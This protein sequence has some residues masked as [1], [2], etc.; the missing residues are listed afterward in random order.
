MRCEDCGT[1][2]RGGLCPNCHEE[3]YI[4]NY[5][6]DTYDGG[7]SREFLERADEQE[8]AARDARR[9]AEARKP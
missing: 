1:K 4:A 8:R 6:S 7:F 5:Q 9:R 2:Y 3:A